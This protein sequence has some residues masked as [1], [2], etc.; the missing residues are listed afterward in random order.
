MRQGTR[1]RGCLLRLR[2]R[3]D[4][5]RAERDGAAPGARVPLLVVAVTARAEGAEAREATPHSR[6]I[7]DLRFRLIDTA[8]SELAIVSYGFPNVSD[9][10]TLHRLDGRDVVVLEVYDNEDGQEGDVRAT[11][12]VDDG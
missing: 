4:Q 9:G 5:G 3:T 8:R 12:V 7:A 1:H 2:A 11:L 6:S 10:D